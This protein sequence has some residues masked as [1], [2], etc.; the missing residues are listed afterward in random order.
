[1]AVL[2]TAFKG[3]DQISAML[4]NIAKNGQHVADVMRDIGGK[5]DAAF[6]EVVNKAQ[7]AG[8]AASQSASKTS[9]MAAA[10]QNAASGADRLSSSVSNSTQAAANA[11]QAMAGAGQKAQ[12]ASQGA[13]RLGNSVRQTGDRFRQ[14]TPEVDQ[15][16]S[17]TQNAIGTLEAL[18]AA[19]GAQRIIQGVADAFRAC[20]GASMEFETAITGIFKT[21]EG[22]AAQLQAITEGVRAMSL[23][24]PATTTEISAVGEAAGQL[25]IAT[26]D[27]LSFSRVMLD[28]GNTTNLSADMAAS[29]LAKFANITKLSAGDYDRLG[30]TIVALGN[31]FATT[32]ADIVAMATNMAS[33]AS[34]AGFTQAQ[35]MALAT[36]MSSV[37]I[38]AEAGG[39]AMSRLINMMQIAAET[40]D[41]LSEFA[42][43]ANMTADQFAEAW[44]S[45]AVG[46]L[47]A[48]I[49]G[50]ND[51][52]RIGMTA[53]AMLEQMGITEIRL[54]NAVRALAQDSEGMGRAVSLANTA[55]EQNNALANEA[56]LRYGTLESRVQMMK[57]AFAN[58]KAALGDAFAPVVGMIADFLR[59]LLT[60][61]A[62]FARK[63]PAV[64]QAIGAVTVAFVA[65]VAALGVYIV[66]LK[67]KNTLEE[68]GIK[69]GIAGAAATTAQG[70]AA[71]AATPPTLAF[72]AALKTVGT[73]MKSAMA[74]MWPVMAIAGAVA[75]L[76][77]WVSAIREA[78]KEYTELAPV[79]RDHYR[80]L[81]ALNEKYAEAK[82]V[83]GENSAEAQN[84]AAEIESLNDE[85][86]RTKMTMD[87]FISKNKEVADSFHNAMN[88]YKDDMTAIE[89]NYNAAAGLARKLSEMSS[90]QMQGGVGKAMAESMASKINELV[91]GAN[92][93]YDEISSSPQAAA[94]KII[95]A[96][97][98]QKQA[99]GGERKVEE[100]LAAVARQ[101]TLEQNRKDA[102]MQYSAL[103]EQTAKSGSS[104]LFNSPFTANAI[105]NTLDLKDTVEAANATLEEARS[106][107]TEN[108]A[109]IEQLL[110]E[111]P[112]SFD[113]A[114]AAEEKMLETMSA[115]ERAA[116]IF[117]AA[118]ISVEE[119]LK[120]LQED[121]D[122][123]YSAAYGSIMGQA[124]LFESFSS[125]VKKAQEEMP[126][127]EEMIGNWIDTAEHATQMDQWI[128]DYLA[129]GGTREAAMQIGI[130]FN[131]E[132][133]S[134]WE[135]IM[136][137][138]ETNGQATV[139]EVEAAFAQL[140]GAGVSL[141]D[142]NAMIVSDFEERYATIAE[143]VQTNMEQAAA[144]L[145]KSSEAYVAAQSTYNS[146][147]NQTKAGLDRVVAYV[148]TA[149]Q[150]ISNALNGAG[151]TI[152][153][154]MSGGGGLEGNA[155]G[156][157]NSAYAFIAGERGP[158]LIVGK[159][160]ST[161]FPASE[162]DRIISA[163]SN[164][165]QA[166]NIVPF[167]VNAPLS[168]APEIIMPQV[169]NII[170]LSG[171]AS[172][173]M[174]PQA[175]DGVMGMQSG[176]TN[177]ITAVSNPPVIDTP[178]VDNIIPFT[179]AWNDGIAA[180]ENF[181]LDAPHMDNIIPFSGE[182]GSGLPMPDKVD[183]TKSG[184]GEMTLKKHIILELAG[185]GII[186]V[187]GDVDPDAVWAVLSPQLK[188]MIL[189]M[190]EDEMTEGGD[191]EY[192]F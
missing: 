139:A 189:D 192:A 33:A 7:Q 163:V 3:I 104:S 122:E 40:G 166:D 185:S 92:V 169:D 17:S 130:E 107:E 147:F 86:E 72:A 63:N 109:L 140:D 134:A 106:N 71:G 74:V 56:A 173:L 174:K 121:Y 47:Q 184:G 178:R 57:N 30:S 155:T 60:S 162:T 164:A 188:Q 180:M 36:S 15:F 114:T 80:R 20:V 127:F 100:Y 172:E 51:T 48:F 19:M 97:E 132:N 135:Q 115:S 59:N 44:G 99:S 145:D 4:K 161:V 165:P 93:T 98:Y 64:V 187:K 50:L 153:I 70:V 177:I 123:A 88:A 67:L 158:E 37:G 27:V 148:E 79:S 83:Y 175:T 143:I 49:G 171:T 68:A 111:L 54:S 142:T 167:P 69:T 149:V 112:A 108:L 82:A 14:T 133:Y 58:F 21:V 156:T 181:G 119:D 116:Q 31:N 144:N 76:M 73:A 113:A 96:A 34:M 117:E 24:M 13:D 91:P 29:A 118:V 38:E 81:E 2:T 32:E 176:I 170:S 136:A 6:D 105:A 168:K 129:A 18:M 131:P 160:G 141:A 154:G 191:R 35:I 53:T 89:D 62:D 190:I 102:E 125:K 120:Q 103:S 12:Q 94:Q 55:W 84:Y 182:E 101:D 65:G 9:E 23:I 90:G 43:V 5:A 78:N 28:L 26:N 77:L 183:A 159:P 52:E 186:E 85:F 87:E 151:G 157:T 66:A 25:G 124:S 150:K 128:N 179:G 152:N 95:S 41:G 61:M 110:G 16:S 137:D 75:G 146:Y 8:Q 11:G 42:N 1:M 39:S 138:F 22:T 126:S 10:M 45:N 46:A